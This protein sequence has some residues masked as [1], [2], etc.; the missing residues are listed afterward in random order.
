MKKWH[1]SY[2]NMVMVRNTDDYRWFL[3]VFVVTRS[4][5]D[6]D[7]A[8]QLIFKIL[9]KNE[10]KTLSQVIFIIIKIIIRFGLHFAYSKVIYYVKWI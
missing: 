6:D 5:K 2:H 7:T 4:D 1:Q 3:N 8:I 9:Y 10:I